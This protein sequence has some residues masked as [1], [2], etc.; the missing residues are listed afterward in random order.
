LEWALDAFCEDA[1]EGDLYV[2]CHWLREAMLHCRVL[3]ARSHMLSLLLHIVRL[4]G[5]L[6]LSNGRGGDNYIPYCAAPHGVLGSKKADK[7]ARPDVLGLHPLMTDAPFVRTYKGGWDPAMEP[8]DGYIPFPRPATHVGKFLDKVLHLLP[9]LPHHWRHFGEYFKLLAGVAEIGKEERLFFLSRRAVSR[10]IDLFLNDESMFSSNR[11]L[12]VKM[13]DKFSSPV[14]SP[15]LDFISVLVRSSNLEIENDED[16]DDLPRPY[17]QLTEVG[18]L[19]N[20]CYKMVNNRAFL[21]K[22]LVD[23]ANYPAVQTLFVHL[24]W[25]NAAKSAEIIQIVCET[26]EE[27]CHEDELQVHLDL[28]AM[29]IA[30]PDQDLPARVDKFVSL[31]VHTISEVAPYMEIFKRCVEFLC[32]LVAHRPEVRKTVIVYVCPSKRRDNARWLES[33]LIKV[34]PDACRAAAYNL[35]CTLAFPS[36]FV[37]RCEP[38]SLPP[39]ASTGGEVTS[40]V[41][42]DRP[43]PDPDTML[44][45]D[46]LTP[47]V[48]DV[49]LSAVPLYSPMAQAADQ[50]RPASTASRLVF[51]FRSILFILKTAAGR[52]CIDRFLKSM[53]DFSVTLMNMNEFR[54]DM[55]YN[56]SELY[57][58]L[59]IAAQRSK[60]EIME[61]LTSDPRWIEALIQ[62]P[63]GSVNGKLQKANLAYNRVHLPMFFRLMKE[64]CTFSAQFTESYFGCQH[65]TFALTNIICLQA[66]NSESAFL[67]LEAFDIALNWEKQGRIKSLDKIR[68]LYLDNLLR[69]KQLVSAPEHSI[70]FLEKIIF[71]SSEPADLMDDIVLLIEGGALETLVNYARS[72]NDSSKEQARHSSLRILEQ[73]F[74]NASTVEKRAP[75]LQLEIKLRKAMQLTECM[76]L[77]VCIIKCLIAPQLPTSFRQQ[78]LGIL[79]Q[80]CRF[81]EE[82]LLHCVSEFLSIYDTSALE[83]VDEVIAARAERSVARRQAAQSQPVGKRS[84]SRGKAKGEAGKKAPVSGTTGEL[85]VLKLH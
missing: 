7:N 66:R 12:F 37:R 83:Q 33:W 51:L 27:E 52:W 11:K 68:H 60:S 13:G 17:T 22:A 46:D 9:D 20:A 44:D 24:S 19:D 62:N 6:E 42:T 31:F 54:A 55:D 81:D 16:M 70:P 5:R 58:I 74:E 48:Y 64:C 15:L 79:L 34:E 75:N 63:L 35:A 85:F 65:G 28:L 38:P 2:S 8:P 1:Q 45:S 71:D 14:F 4:L 29:L 69:R 32:D 49:L 43:E 26:I 41:A 30:I 3:E 84:S 72:F 61:R 53:P 25:F 40:S 10:C 23:G 50:C 21:N 78:Y 47:I 36:A 67:L 80:L 73:I 18:E 82:A 59:L 57:K 56:R 39:G 77:A 76:G